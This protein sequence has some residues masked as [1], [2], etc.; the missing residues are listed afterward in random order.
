[1]PYETSETHGPAI[2]RKLLAFGFPEGVLYNLNF[3]NRAPDAVEG[4]AITAQGKIAHGLHIEERF[5]GRGNQYFWLAY[6][7]GKGR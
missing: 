7:R 5:D 3:P 4:I 6:R 1:M 2:I